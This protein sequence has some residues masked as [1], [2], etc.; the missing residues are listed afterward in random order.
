M[1]SE[2]NNL[3]LDNDKKRDLG[4]PIPMKK[5]KSLN[6]FLANKKK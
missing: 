2:L 5:K 1:I 4:S 6:E 3:Y